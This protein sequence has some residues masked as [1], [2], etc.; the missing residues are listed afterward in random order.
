MLE[1]TTLSSLRLWISISIWK[2]RNTT[3]ETKSAPSQHSFCHIATCVC[4]M[5]TMVYTEAEETA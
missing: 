4:Y 3:Q 2:Y 5:C 1:A